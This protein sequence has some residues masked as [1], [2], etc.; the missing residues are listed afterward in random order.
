[1]KPG[2]SRPGLRPP[3]RVLHC[4][5]GSQAQGGL[6]PVALSASRTLSTS[7]AQCSA[8]PLVG[9][10]HVVEETNTIT[11]LSGWWAPQGAEGGCSW[12]DSTLPFLIRM[13]GGG[14][15][16]ESGRWRQLAGLQQRLHDLYLPC[17][18]GW[19]VGVEGL[20]QEGSLRTLGQCIWERAPPPGERG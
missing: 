14:R 3:A 20:T 7:Q 19:G 6:Q 4:P 13:C 11:V 18:L 10:L 9:P 12:K 16:P 8:C 5:A 1:M 2:F 17:E 15:G